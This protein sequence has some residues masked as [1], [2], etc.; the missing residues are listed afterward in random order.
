MTHFGN[1]L[2]SAHFRG[3]LSARERCLRRE[4]LYPAELSG[5]GFSVASELWLVPNSVR[6]TARAMSEEN[7]EIVRRLYALWEDEPFALSNE[8]SELLDPEVEWDVS[9]RTF[10]P[11]IYH[12][13][14]GLRE[15]VASL[16]EVWESGHIVPLEFIPE[17]DVVVVP[18]RLE[19]VSRTDSQAVT[20]NAAHL[21]TLRGGKVVRHCV[22]QTRG[23][24][25]E[26]AGL[27][28]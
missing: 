10:D 2:Q 8:A 17:G 25:L 13:H 21:W 1:S 12:G 11:A 24:A 16:A 27:S 5:R 6:D 19:L 15:F 22:F 9:R 7:V 18:V 20:A 4:S 26:A 3:P 28:E 14:A 23:E